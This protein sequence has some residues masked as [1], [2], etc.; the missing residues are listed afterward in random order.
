MLSEGERWLIFVPADETKTGADIE[1]EVSDILLPYL[2]YYLE[3]VRPKMIRD[4]K[5]K[6]LW[7]STLG[8]PFSYE[9][10]VKSFARISVRLGVR[11]SPH[12]VRDAAATLWAIAVPDQIEVACDLL[13]YRDLRQMRH[14]NRARG[15]EASR[16]YGRLISQMRRQRRRAAP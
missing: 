4:R 2:T 11:V 14:Y 16:A 3:N 8:G 6:S 7:I 13:T 1:F 12:D 10:L 9:G 15:V 5:C